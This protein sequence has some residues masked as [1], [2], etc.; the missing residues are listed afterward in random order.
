VKKSRIIILIKFIIYHDV[1]IISFIHSLYKFLVPKSIKF[2]Y[3]K[4]LT[5]SKVQ[6]IRISW[7]KKLT[8]NV[9]RKYLKA[10]KNFRGL[11]LKYDIFIEIKK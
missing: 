3:Y 8:K 7:L 11:K 1:S 4:I 2:I 10:K 6:M 5:Y 9:D